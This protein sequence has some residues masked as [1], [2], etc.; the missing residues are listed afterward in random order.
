MT[1]CSSIPHYIITELENT[2]KFEGPE[3]PLLAGGSY[4]LTCVVTADLLPEVKWRDG[5]GNDVLHEAN[6]NGGM[7]V[8]EEVNGHVTRLTLRF[9]SLLASHGGTYSCL[10][11]IAAPSS[12]Q[13]STRDVIVKSE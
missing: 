12:I 9:P 10:S 8:E 6:E 7:L 13:I 5:E 1:L 3:N 4:S 11:I 2:I